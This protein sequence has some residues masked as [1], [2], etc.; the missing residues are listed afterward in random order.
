MM[1]LGA[2]VCIPNGAPLC[3]KCPLAGLCLAHGDGTELDYP[4]KAHA[5]GR[6]IEKKTVLLIRDA[7]YTVIRKRPEKG[8]LAGMYEFPWLD[9]F[10]TAEE[11]IAY[12][13]RNG[14]K[15]IRI[16]PLE[17]VKHIFTHKEWHMKGYV[18]QTDELEQ[19]NPGTEIKD[20]IYI[21]PEETKDQYPMPSAFGAYMKRLQMKLDKPK[22]T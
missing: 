5:K 7:E 10:R 8:L 22:H 15:T 13:E 2:C 14:V 3:D 11:V 4:R 9:G 20:W 18:V 17:D 1:E 12:L 6:K 16:V 21:R 19:R